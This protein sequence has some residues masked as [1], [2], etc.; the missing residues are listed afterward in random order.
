MLNI[1]GRAMAIMFDRE[2]HRT[3]HFCTIT[4]HFV[5]GQCRRAG[6]GQFWQFHVI[7]YV[8]S[9]PNEDDALSQI[10]QHRP[11]Y[12]QDWPRGEAAI[13]I[14]GLKMLADWKPSVA[15]SERRTISGLEIEVLGARL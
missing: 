4:G 10:L 9:A 14:V 8:V 11:S 2:G 7:D 6:A 12:A 13:A 3:R 1:G 5:I 15:E